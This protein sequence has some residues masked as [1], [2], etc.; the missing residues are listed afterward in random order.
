MVF[1]EGCKGK[2]DDCDNQKDVGGDGRNSSRSLGR[3]R[4]KE[5]LNKLLGGACYTKSWC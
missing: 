5:K 3:R 1:G 2:H 4:G